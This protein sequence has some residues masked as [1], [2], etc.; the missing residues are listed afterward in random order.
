M[1]REIVRVT[2]RGKVTIPQALRRRLG[3]QQGSRIEFLLVDDHM[4]MRVVHLPESAPASG[5]GMLKS[6]RTAVPA[7]FDPALLMKP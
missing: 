4:E 1:D 6:P 7:D 2:S 5:F 3:I